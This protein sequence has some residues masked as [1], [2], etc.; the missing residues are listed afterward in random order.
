MIH[1][2]AHHRIRLLLLLGLIL[3]V[4]GTGMFMILENWSFIDALYFTVST[5]TTV[6][7]GDITPTLPSTRLLTTFYMALTVPLMIITFG[8]IAESIYYERN[9]E[10]IIKK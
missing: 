7:Y 1:H 8:V 5:L 3:V 6:G 2:L 10:R 9:P 4:F